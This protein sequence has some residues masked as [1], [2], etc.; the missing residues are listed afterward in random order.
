MVTELDQSL[1]DWNKRGALEEIE[2]IKNI[3]ATVWEEHTHSFRWLMA[4]LLA[5]N[6]AACW[7]VAGME[8]IGVISR[9]WSCGIFASGILAALLVAVFGQQ[10]VRSSL[11]PLQKQIGYWMTVAEDGERSESVEEDLNREL[12]RSARIGLGGR[13]AGWISAGAFAAGLAIAGIGLMASASAQSSNVKA[14][15]PPCASR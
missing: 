9:L 14:P 3:R 8:E 11:L 12:K 5:I 2:T 4:S 10:S 6:A 1:A 7:A 15:N 13:I